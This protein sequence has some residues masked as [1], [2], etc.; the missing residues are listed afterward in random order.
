MT[1]AAISRPDKEAVRARVI[2]LR[3]LDCFGFVTPSAFT[4]AVLDALAVVDGRLGAALVVDFGTGE[5][6]LLKKAEG[7]GILIVAMIWM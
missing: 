6:G 1:V 4:V 2:P 3:L 7:E 5:T